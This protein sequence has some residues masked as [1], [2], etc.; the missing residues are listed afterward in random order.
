[1]KKILR[2]T[3]YYGMLAQNRQQYEEELLRDLSTNRKKIKLHNINKDS[4][5]KESTTDDRE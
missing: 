4:I 1:M 5:I 3:M 2:Q